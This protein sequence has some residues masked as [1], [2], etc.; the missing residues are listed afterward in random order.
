MYLRP[1][2][3]FCKASYN[4]Q[5]GGAHDADALLRVC[6]LDGPGGGRVRECSAEMEPRGG[7]GGSI[8]QHTRPQ[9]V[10]DDPSI[11]LMDSHRHCRV[12][13]SFSFPLLLCC[14]GGWNSTWGVEDSNAEG[15][16]TE[17]DLADTK[18]TGDI[19]NTM[20]HFLRKET[21]C[22][23]THEYEC[24]RWRPL[25]RQNQLLDSTDGD[26]TVGG[27]SGR[28]K[29]VVLCY[30]AL[31]L[32]SPIHFH[33]PPTPPRMWGRI[34]SDVSGGHFWSQDPHFTKVYAHKILTF[35]R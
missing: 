30:G 22:T 13:S 20:E 6:G 3:S 31:C 8:R 21:H 26:G 2:K 4:L 7:R 10:S 32:C 25:G 23:F 16:R 11:T 1:G 27:C 28:C 19:Y 33:S 9:C 14:Q 5:H 17:E 29:R 12:A 35:D 24:E 34:E 18:G 15:E